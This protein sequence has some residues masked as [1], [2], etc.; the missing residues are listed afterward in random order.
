MKIEIK[1]RWNN[2]IIYTC[3]VNNVKEGVL[4]AIKNKIDLSGA[5]LS[6]ADLSRAKL[7]RANLS[8]AK[9]SRANLSGAD[10]SWADLSRAN[11]SGADL[12]GADLSRAKLSRADLSG[13]DLSCADLS[14]ANLSGAKLSRAKLSRAKLSRANLS[15][16]DLSCANLSGAN[17]SGA[18]LSWADLSWA[19]LSGA[20]L[21]EIKMDNKN[22][23]ILVNQRLIAPEGDLIVYKKLNN[24][25]IAKLLIPKDAKRVGGLIGRK[26]RA[27]FVEVIE[28]NGFSLTNQFSKIEYKSGARIVPDKFDP[29]PLVEC[30]SGIHFFLTRQEAED[31]NM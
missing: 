9:L 13:A 6:W 2:S 21:L 15:G 22:L 29:N 8:R 27:E 11:L 14:G 16:A 7:S 4:L 30:S 3:E 23:Q 17:L 18:N 31:F 19:D 28:G 1:N 20:D 12:S 26:C 25:N 10:L 5:D 24:G